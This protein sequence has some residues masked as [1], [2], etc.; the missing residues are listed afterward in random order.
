[1]V[2]NYEITEVLN[3]DSDESCREIERI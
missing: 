1:M 2:N 3:R